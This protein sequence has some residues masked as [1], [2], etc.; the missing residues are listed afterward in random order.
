MA[1][2]F[3]FASTVLALLLYLTYSDYV[4]DV[5]YEY[6]YVPS[7]ASLKYEKDGCEITEWDGTCSVGLYGYQWVT[8]IHC[9]EGSVHRMNG[10]NTFG[11]LNIINIAGEDITFSVH[12]GDNGTLSIIGDYLWISPGSMSDI[13]ITGSAYVFGGRPTLTPMDNKDRIKPAKHMDGIITSRVY[14]IMDGQFG[15]D[16]HINDGNA[17]AFDVIYST[18]HLIDP[19]YVMVIDCSNDSYVSNH[20]HP[21]N[22]LYFPLTDG[23]LYFITEDGQTT[24]GS[25]VTGFPRWVSATLRYFECLYLLYAI[26]EYTVDC[27]VY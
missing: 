26:T 8:T 22:A 4:Y 5:P 7:T 19:P 3:P 16:P 24:L 6:Y 17:M 23:I 21:W 20:Y 2:S 15:H 25:S 10:I 11:E 14:H 12:N 1:T 13:N 9:N 27:V 18:K